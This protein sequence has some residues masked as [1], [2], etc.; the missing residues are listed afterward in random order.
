MEVAT[1]HF[2]IGRGREVDEVV[3]KPKK[4]SDGPGR[5]TWKSPE[6]F[7]VDSHNS[8]NRSH[9]IEANGSVGRA[10]HQGKRFR[11]ADVPR[12]TLDGLVPGRLDDL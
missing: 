7:L 9:K 6:P 5:R 12:R 3:P 4:E 11:V 8:K 10:D 2:Q 1:V